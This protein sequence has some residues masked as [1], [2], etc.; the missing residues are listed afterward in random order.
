MAAALF[1]SKT[2]YCKN[3]G[4]YHGQAWMCNKCG[5]KCDT[6]AGWHTCATCPRVPP[7]APKG[8]DS[9]L[10]R[11]LKRQH[12]TLRLGNNYFKTHPRQK[13][14]GEKSEEKSAKRRRT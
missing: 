9:N 6:K 12:E 3:H 2:P 13:D 8:P 4:Q 7:A 11:S 10:H 14:E 1:H 5:K